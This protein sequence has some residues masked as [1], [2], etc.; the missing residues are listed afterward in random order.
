LSASAPRSRTESSSSGPTTPA[1]LNQ[2][3][4]NQNHSSTS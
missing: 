2:R 4:H 1:A 3:R